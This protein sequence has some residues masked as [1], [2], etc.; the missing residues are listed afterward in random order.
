MTTLAGDSS[1]VLS[2]GKAWRARK[3]HHRQSE[4]VFSNVIQP[5]VAN[6]RRSGASMCMRK[7][8]SALPDLIGRTIRH[9]VVSEHEDCRTQVFLHF[10]DGTY[11]E[12]FGTSLCGIRHLDVGGLEVSR[13]KGLI[14]A[15]GRL[16]ILDVNTSSLT[17]RPNALAA[18]PSTGSGTSA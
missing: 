6:I 4:A 18:H 7:F 5:T 2:R 11:Y 15:N 3:G 17:E 10:T 14:P 8:Q 9:I 13:A 16:E 12:F 1:I